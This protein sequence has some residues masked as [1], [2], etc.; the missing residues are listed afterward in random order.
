[1]CI[2]TISP[3]IKIIQQLLKPNELDAN[4]SVTVENRFVELLQLNNQF[5]IN[6]KSETYLAYG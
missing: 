3:L 6:P 5:I 4:I 2:C 1:M